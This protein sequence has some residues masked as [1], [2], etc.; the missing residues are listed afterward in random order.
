MLNLSCP[1][2]IY[3]LR[4]L[5]RYLESCENGKRLL[6]IE[7]DGTF[8]YSSSTKSTYP[9]YTNFYFIKTPKKLRHKYEAWGEFG[10]KG[11]KPWN[12]GYFNGTPRDLLIM[13]KNAISGKYPRSLRMQYVLEEIYS[14][15]LS[16]QEQID[17]IDSEYL[18]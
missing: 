16:E 8:N 11:L 2:T 1:H 15:Y 14:C 7:H 4:N 18:F 13:I 6:I 10:I 12:H 17:Y 9:E 3:N 5:L